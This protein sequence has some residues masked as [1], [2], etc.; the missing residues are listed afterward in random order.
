VVIY[1]NVKESFSAHDAALKRLNQ[2]IN[3]MQMPS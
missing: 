1:M 2:L 3:D